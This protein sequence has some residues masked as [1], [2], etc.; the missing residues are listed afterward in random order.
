MRGVLQ[1][2]KLL[3]TIQ[4][5]VFLLGVYKNE[6]DKCFE[7]CSNPTRR[8]LPKTEGLGFQMRYLQ[9]SIFTLAICSKDF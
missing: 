5:T 3:Q 6:I 9:I 4:D 8:K 2:S 7:V 1:Q